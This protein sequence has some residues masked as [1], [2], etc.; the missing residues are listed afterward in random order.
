MSKS[1]KVS[2]CMITYGHEKFIEEAI[3]G[4]LM[5]EVDFQVE[6]I[7]SN[8]A[9][10]D[11]T[12]EIVNSIIGNH[13]RGNWI[14][15]IKHESN[16][17]MMLNSQFVLQASKGEFIAIC[18]GDDYWTDPLKLKKQIDFLEANPD[19][20][21]C[22]HRCQFLTLEN[23]NLNLFNQN[24]KMIDYEYNLYGL[25][26]YWNIPTASIVFR[27]VFLKEENVFPQEFL[28]VKSGDIALASYLFQF[29]KFFLFKEM[30]CVYRIFG[31]GVSVTHK[32]FR[33]IHYR[34]ELYCKI[35][36]YYNFK[37]E[38]E[39]YKALHDIMNVYEPTLCMEKKRLT[40]FSTRK[41]INDLFSLLKNK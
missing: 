3:N 13:P 22:F 16:I 1:I 2:V 34:A 19:Y 24:L 8:D 7:I 23:G 31:L 4:V 20:V 36:E 11:R 27:N 10:P 32:D 5:Q 41:L 39:I 6:L 25:L 18:E 14:N 17:G 26:Y 38:R 29:G 12:H 33:M 28:N 40:N 21:M 35:N 9:S 15:Y 37:Y 30:M